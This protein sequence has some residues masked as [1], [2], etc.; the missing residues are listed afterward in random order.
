M[1]RRFIVLR[2]RYHCGRDDVMN[3]DSTGVDNQHCV[4]VTSGRHVCLLGGVRQFCRFAKKS[5]AYN[6]DG[7]FIRSSF[8]VTERPAASIY[9]RGGLCCTGLFISFRCHVVHPS[10]RFASSR[11]GNARD[12][13]SLEFIKASTS[14]SLL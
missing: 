1:T 11:W 14:L 4:C 6:R 8:V 9:T 12:D 7:D 5:Q 13:L 10:C 2:K 3:Q